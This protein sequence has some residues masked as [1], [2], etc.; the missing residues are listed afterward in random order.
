MP[1]HQHF[2]G[3]QIHHTE[4]SLNV[5]VLSHSYWSPTGHNDLNVDKQLNLKKDPPL[6]ESKFIFGQWQHC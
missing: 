5:L 1:K 6:R 4:G 3:L 2:N